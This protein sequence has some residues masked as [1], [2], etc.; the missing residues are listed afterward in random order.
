MLRINFVLSILV[1]TGV[2][3]VVC[4]GCGEHQGDLAP[5]ANAPA[6]GES[7]ETSPNG[8]GTQPALA[9]SPELEQAL[10]SLSSEDRVLAAR[11]RVCPVS[12]KPLGSMGTPVK[13]R[14]RDRDVLLCCEGCDEEI[15]A[16]PEKYLVK[17]PQ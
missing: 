10:A 17:L 1:L 14:V 2:T 6:G 5:V 7:Q 13:V 8:A 12:E 16:N 11:Q 15:Q 4:G 3:L 9:A